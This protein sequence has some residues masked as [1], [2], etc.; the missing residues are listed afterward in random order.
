MWCDSSDWNRLE[1][2]SEDIEFARPHNLVHQV[3]GVSVGNQTHK[4]FGG[5][6]FIDDWPMILSLAEQID[7]RQRQ[8]LLLKLIILLRQIEI[9]LVPRRRQFRQRGCFSVQRVN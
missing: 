8:R 7:R 1:H 9:T 2:A 5:N 6:E 3:S 4:T